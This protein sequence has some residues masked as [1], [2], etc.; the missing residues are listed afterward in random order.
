MRILELKLC[1]FPCFIS[2]R[3]LG[4]HFHS[5]VYSSRFPSISYSHSSPQ[6]LLSLSL[7]LSTAC[8]F[9]ASSCCI[10]ANTHTDNWLQP[11]WLPLIHLSSAHPLPSCSVLLAW[12]SLSDSL[13]FG[14]S[15]SSG[16]QR[17]PLNAMGIRGP[18][19]CNCS[20]SSKSRGR[21][22]NLPYQ[23]KCNLL[24][25]SS[26]QLHL[27]CLLAFRLPFAIYHLP[28]AYCRLPNWPSN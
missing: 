14:F 9:L 15:D 28:F 8:I 19:L 20:T 26:S 4:I 2:F 13:F 27:I 11:M 23:S 5:F 18:L 10:A 7:A 6:S 25:V 21:A 3:L 17:Q 12:L 16:R 24:Q 22:L 1:N